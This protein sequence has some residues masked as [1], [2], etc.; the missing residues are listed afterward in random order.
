[1]PT[2]PLTAT[3][4]HLNLGFSECTLNVHLE[5]L[6]ELKL[7]YSE[8]DKPA[9]SDTPGAGVVPDSVSRFVAVVVRLWNRAQNR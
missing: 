2:Q 6:K 5:H 4:N 3:V 1:M 9:K 7:I 8:P